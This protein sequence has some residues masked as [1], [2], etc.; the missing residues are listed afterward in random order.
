MSFECM[1][2]SFYTKNPAFLNFPKRGGG[3][4]GGGGG[5]CPLPPAQMSLIRKD[6]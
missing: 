1:L 5:M 2:K 4:G 3:G 6:S